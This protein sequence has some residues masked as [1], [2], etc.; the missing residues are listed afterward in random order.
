MKVR[1]KFKVKANVNQHGVVYSYTVSGTTWEGARVRQSY[2]SE[3]EALLE[4][5]RLR[6]P[7]SEAEPAPYRCHT[8]LSPAALADAENANFIKPAGTSLTDLATK[9][10]RKKQFVDVPLSQLRELYRNW[11]KADSNDPERRPRTVGGV[12]RAA[13]IF[14]RDNGDLW[15]SALV[16]FDYGTWRCHETE[17]RHLSILLTWARGQRPRYMPHNP[18]LEILKDLPKRT[19]KEN[20]PPMPID[21]LQRL[22]DASFR[23]FDGELA[24][25][26]VC[27]VGAVT[28]PENETRYMSNDLLFFH[29]RR[30]QV[31]RSRAK[32]HDTKDV[33]LLP[34]WL[35]CLQRWD[36][37]HHTF[38]K[39]RVNVTRRLDALKEFAGYK[40]PNSQ[41]C[42]R[43]KDRKKQVRWVRNILRKTGLT[44]HLALTGDSSKTATWGRTSEKMLEGFYIGNTTYRWAVQLSF[45]LPHD[46]SRKDREKVYFETIVILRGTRLMRALK[47]YLRKKGVSTDLCGDDPLHWDVRAIARRLAEIISTEEAA[48]EVVVPVLTR[49]GTDGA[50]RVWDKIKQLPPEEIEKLLQQCPAVKWSK[51]WGIS[52]RGIGKWCTKHNIKTPGR[53]EWAKM[54]QKYSDAEFRMMSETMTQSEIAAQ[55]GYHP[56]SVRLRAKALDIPLR[57]AA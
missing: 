50:P 26:V 3:A 27:Q 11:A 23:M 10:A 25:L 28:R 17:L 39:A 40:G 24:G 14:E 48:R 38:E 15:T 49:P 16:E 43:A 12:V 37:A 46:A 36:R 54:E 7:A 32:R 30:L 2:E 42:Y 45:L 8:K 20:P 52:A 13:R 31:R 21:N 29:E 44:F 5:Q 41:K 57:R 22:L 35:Y 19:P 47:N 53:G 18:V 4:A 1:G 56:D 55:T 6:K 33:D 34:N 51:K 9:A